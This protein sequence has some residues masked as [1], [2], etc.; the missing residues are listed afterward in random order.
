M[1][2]L[3]SF[4]SVALFT[5]LALNVLAGDCP[6]L[7]GEYKIGKTDADYASITEAV[8][9]LKC[10][11]VSGAV[12]FLIQ[13][14]KYNERIEL[15]SINGTSAQNTVSFESLKGSNTDVVLASNT[16]DAEYTVGLNGTSFVSFEGLTIEN[17]TGNTGNALRID[18]SARNLRF[19]N[20]SFDGTDKPNTGAN[21]AV[22]YSTSK[23]PKASMASNR[24]ANWPMTCSRNA[25]NCTDTT[26]AP[27]HQAFGTTNG[28]QSCLSSS[29]MTLAS[30]TLIADT[31]NTSCT[32]FK[33]ITQSPPTGPVLNLLALTSR[34]TTPSKPST[35]PWTHT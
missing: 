7:S 25:W 22:V 10:G 11:G 32:P 31:Q 34:G 18:G 12:T 16:P 27:Q 5:P 26:N 6:A 20:V 1:S 23:Q 33:S 24:P 8:T 13:D 29:S 3:K 15:G 30:N 4:F 2:T 21:S 9:A 35:L 28:D 17:K 14:G 19:K